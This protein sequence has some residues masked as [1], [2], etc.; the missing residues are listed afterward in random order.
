[1]KRHIVFIYVTHFQRLTSNFDFLT[2]SEAQALSQTLN[3]VVN[4]FFVVLIFWIF[5]NGVYQE[6]T[7]KILKQ[8]QAY[9]TQIQFVAIES[10]RFWDFFLLIWKN[11][12][13]KTIV[14]FYCIVSSSLRDKMAVWNGVSIFSFVV[15]CWSLPNGL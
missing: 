3:T 2:W 10:Y 5:T 8:Q 7:N 13:K 15:R 6:R 4:F 14:F 1:M 9:A 11:K 12:R